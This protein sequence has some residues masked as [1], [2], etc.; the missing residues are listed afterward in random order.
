MEATNAV[1]EGAVQA[2]RDVRTKEC[3]KHGPYTQVF[4]VYSRLANGIWHGNCEDCD[5]ERRE[6]AAARARDEKLSELYQR[7]G[8]PPRLMR[9]H[10]CDYI[11]RT[12]VQAAAL[13]ACQKHAA[14]LGTCLTLVG[15]PGTGKSHLAVAA[16]HEVIQ[17]KL[18]S[19]HY[20]TM[21]DF[22]ALV[23]GNWA[24]NGANA[25]VQPLIWTHL[26]VLDEIWVPAS[27]R[28]REAVLALVDARYRA[29]KPTIIASNLTWPQLKEAL[30]E[31]TCDRLLEDGG[32]VIPLDGESFRRH[33]ETK[34]GEAA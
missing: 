10:F 16:A 15:P 20:I 2:A 8:I 7:A 22:L 30:G 19:A 9:K 33:A 23:K 18:L 31:R 11:P 3:A 1:G 12:K 29:C 17:T 5:R 13:A 28:D 14:A 24:W 6:E 25:E 32:K 26:L 4:S 21:V 34:V 27:D